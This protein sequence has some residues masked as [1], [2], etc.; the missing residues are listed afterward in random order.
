MAISGALRRSFADGHLEAGLD[1][2]DDLRELAETAE[3]PFDSTEKLVGRVQRKIDKIDEKAEE[4]GKPLQERKSEITAVMGDGAARVMTLS[5][6]DVIHSLARA[7][8]M[9]VQGPSTVM[10]QH[11]ESLRYVTA[12]QVNRHRRMELSDD[13][14]NPKFHR[15]T[16]QALDLGAAFGLAAAERI[17]SSLHPGYR[18]TAVDADLVLEAGWKLRGLKTSARG[19]LNLRPDCFLVGLKPGAPLRVASVRCKGSH[20]KTAGPQYDQLARSSANLVRFV[21]GDLEDGGGPPP[22]LMLSTAILGNGGIETRVLDPEGNGLLRVPGRGVPDL[23]GEPEQ[24]N[25]LPEIPF[26]EGG[27]DCSRAGFALPAEEWEWF[28]KVLVRASAASLLTFAGDRVNAASILTTDQ[29]YRLGE[30]YSQAATGVELDTGIRL[31]GIKFVGTDHVFRLRR[32]RVEVFSGIPNELHER[33]VAKD[34][35]GFER[36]LP[37]LLARWRACESHV[38]RRDW[39]GV[40]SMDSGGTLFAIRREGCGTR[41]LE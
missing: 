37:G 5:P 33:L 17:M 38:R 36:A 13:G 25:F 3:V 2:T 10:A 11:W 7:K 12:F 39:N 28:S 19:V 35:D 1:V 23:A 24:R 29:Q 30:Q 16:V 40:A 41:R 8:T 27:R 21:L 15:R 32:S 20:A 14:K 6:W 31:G 4:A 26:K 22:G 9:S 34:Y 18:F